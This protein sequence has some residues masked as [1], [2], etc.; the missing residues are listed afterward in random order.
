M[1]KIVPVIARRWFRVVSLLTFA[2]SVGAQT[3][4]SIYTDALQNGWDDWS[5]SATLDFNS[6]AQFHS[7][8]KAIAVNLNGWG[9]LSLH[10]ADINTSNYT[11]L[12]FWVHGGATGGQQ[13]KIFAELGTTPQSSL[14][15]PTLTANTWQQITFSLA[16]LGVANQ[17]NFARFSIQNNTDS[18]APTFYVDDMALVTNSHPSAGVTLTAPTSGTSFFAL[19]T[20]ALAAT[21]NTNG[22][23][24]NKV[25]FYNGAT[26]LGED[27]S[28]PYGYTWSN[29]SVGNYTLVAK[30]TFD[31]GTPSAGILD[32]PPANISVISNMPVTI[33]V[34]AA[35]NV[36]PINPMIYG[37][38]FATSNQLAELNAT[39]NR[40]GG[41]T[42]SRYNW[43]LNAHNRGA[44]WYFESI[45]D[46]P[47][48]AGGT[49]HNHIT[50]SKNGGAQ[51]MLTIP[52]LGWVPK[53]TADR[54]YLASYPISKYGPQTDHDTSYYLWN[55]FGN[56]VGTNT[57]NHTSWV[58]TTNDPT[59]ANFLTNSLYQQ[60]FVAH[61]T[62]RWGAATNGGVRF[63]CLDN[64]H[65]L[66]YSTHRDIHPIGPTMQEIRDKMF[67][68]G[69]R[70][71]SVDPNALLV[72]P[73]EWGWPGYL[74]SG[75]DWQWAGAHGDYDPAHFP[76]RSANGGWDY[77]P[78]LL[79][80]ARR[81]EQTNGYRLLDVFT[82]HIYPQGANESGN[83]VSTTTQLGRNRSTRA[84]WDTNYVDQSWINSVIKLIP[85]MKD[86]VATFYPGTKIG[87]TE[88]NW[89]AENHI[90]GATA[91]A[92]ILGI[93]GREGLDYATR[94]TTPASTTPT[95]KAM[96]MYR[97]YDGNKSTFGDQSVSANG[98][99]PDSIACFA[100]RRSSDGALTIM[101][102]NK[103]IGTNA[104]V[105]ISLAGFLPS[106]TAQVWQLTSANTIAHLSDLTFSGGT[107]SNTLPAQS[108]TLFVLPTGTP[109]QFQAAGL[110]S[111]N[112]FLSR[113]NGRA[114]ERYAILASS[115]FANWIPVQTNTQAGSSLSLTLPATNAWRF[116]RAQWLP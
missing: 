2:A 114:G 63:Y 27:L 113:L 79:D 8:A 104:S 74:Y 111:S 64:E 93:F 54:S 38:A 71:K 33:T 90:N 115:N 18:T 30:L 44:D 77:G 20:I 28:P 80:Q 82:F 110:T 57:T 49:A 48:A 34:N 47:N 11:N 116:F 85:R 105:N 88:Y 95:F 26:L 53:L 112:T 14:N 36:H 43:Q 16:A 52:M 68:Y 42:E 50:Q 75:F 84:L 32:S 29:V 5:W 86:W 106:G 4:Q 39:L 25:Q 62:N 9:G 69:A 12:T 51:P 101:A 21:V 81:F 99:N 59:D 35:L 23:I 108:V 15:L 19:A 58:I 78:W 92:D 94:W 61:I 10:H 56:G 73:E 7:G 13:L 6:S 83:D 87:V 109:P 55:D 100:A 91:Q 102:I 46:S 67:D 24:I 17:P 76:D 89:G 103:Q 31:S 22:H 60:A 98:P 3:N 45:P 40:S 66:W 107:F 70:V 96:K 37:V 1:L 72:A 41:N 65:T 97:N